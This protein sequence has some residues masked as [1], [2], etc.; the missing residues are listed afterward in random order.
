MADGF[1]KAMEKKRLQKL[2]A[3][4]LDQSLSQTARGMLG[5][6]E[7]D[8]Q[9]TPLPVN[10]ETR[11]P[12]NRITGRSSLPLGREGERLFAALQEQR[13]LEEARNEAMQQEIEKV[14]Q[15]RAKSFGRGIE[16]LG[17]VMPRP[18]DEAKSLMESSAPR[19]DAD[20][21]QSVL[22]K[23]QQRSRQSPEREESDAESGPIFKAPGTPPLVDPKAQDAAD[24]A[25]A[26][27]KRKEQSLEDDDKGRQQGKKKKKKKRR[28]REDG[29]ED[30]DS[31]Y[32]SA[33]RIKAP[34]DDKKRSNA[35]G[36]DGDLL[37]DDHTKRSPACLPKGGFTDADLAKRLDKEK[38]GSNDKSL[39]SEEQVLKKMGKMRKDD[40]RDAEKKKEKKEEKAQ[41]KR[42][43]RYKSEDRDDRSRSRDER[44]KDDRGDRRRDGSRDRRRDGSERRRDPS[45]R[46]SRGRRNR[47]RSDS[48]RERRRSGSRS[49]DRDRRRH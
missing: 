46:R 11:G 6:T 28:G 49:R 47:D 31:D 24:D 44:R 34:D 43:Q 29:D 2:A 27:R 48:R 17:P 42:S 39:M 40:E 1:G 37:P 23:L 9:I 3:M 4:G 41:Q 18:A 19:T 10:K 20:S 33:E 36:L 15:N 12:W 14:Q 25:A 8:R 5:V 45:E 35:G 38:D 22:A 16:R 13:G 21:N 7:K 32:S 26:K 30:G